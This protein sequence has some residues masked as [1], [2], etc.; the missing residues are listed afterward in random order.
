MTEI[1]LESHKDLQFLKSNISIIARE[2]VD[3]HLPPTAL[4]NVHSDTL[5]KRVEEILHE[6]FIARCN[7]YI[8]IVCITYI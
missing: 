6:V 2:K 3:I 5:R 7:P 4:Q 8:D 1:S